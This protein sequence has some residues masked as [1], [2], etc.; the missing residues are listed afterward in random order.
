M[1]QEYRKRIDGLFEAM[2][3]KQTRLEGR[4][5]ASSQH[6]SSLLALTRRHR[7]HVRLKAFKL[8]A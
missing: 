5:C 7:R 1:A 6:A 3:D 2:Q 8:F 4:A